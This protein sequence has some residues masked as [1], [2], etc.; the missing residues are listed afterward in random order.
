MAENESGLE[1]SEEPTERRLQ[2]AREKGQAPRSRELNT[3]L[4][5]LTGA[6]ALLFSGG[7]LVRAL[8]RVALEV[9]TLEREL[10]FDGP[11]GLALGTDLIAEG[12]IALAPLL[13]LLLLA[14]LFGPMVIGGWL[15]AAGNL[16]PKLEKLDPVK[17][18]K[19][20]FGWQGLMELLKALG[21]FLLLAGG[22][23]LLLLNTVDQLM[24]LSW[25]SIEAALRDGMQLLALSFLLLSALLII[26]AA[27]DVP[28][29]LWQHQ[30]QLRMTKQELKDELKETEGQPEVKGRQR[31]LMREMSLQRMIFEVPKADVVVTNP[32]HYAVALRYE[33]AVGAP[34]V[35]AKGV[36]E[37]ALA[38]RAAARE[39][40]I[41]IVP[42]PPLARALYVS[43]R[44]GERI[45]EGL[46]LAV[47][48][49]LAY[50]Y[51]LEA[52]VRRERGAR[53]P[54]LPTDLPIP[55]EYR[56]AAEGGAGA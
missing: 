41:A 27:V 34:Q 12:F 54:V 2:Q 13:G 6:V 7:L 10:I 9:F 49:V 18:L 4:V 38:I 17:G 22:A 48:Q 24:A 37:V 56:A 20:I 8:G 23:M 50:V 14:A 43:C 11:R 47:A 46:Y 26:I 3:M 33:A 42:A 21:K 40:R 5:L 28:F 16:V 39:H 25:Q 1:K 31:Q 35:V 19:R 36:D 52:R 15:F 44:I 29:Q 32:A 45:P 30:R 51:Q 55:E 53:A